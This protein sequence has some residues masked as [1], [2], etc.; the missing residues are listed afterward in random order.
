MHA[1][2]CSTTEPHTQPCGLKISQML[3]GREK[4]LS[5]NCVRP[6]QFSKEII[7]LR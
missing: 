2:K 4:I 5:S 3:E 1:D 6:G 7:V